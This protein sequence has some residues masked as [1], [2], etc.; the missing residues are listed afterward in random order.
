MKIGIVGLPNV[1]KST[2]FKA[3][4][5]KQVDIQNYPFC[6]ID[7]NIG[8][9]EV[10]DER[11]RKLAIFSQSKKIVPTVIEFV[12][13][14]GLVKGAAE[15]AGLGNKFLSHIREVDAIAQVIRIFENPDIIHVPNKIDPISDIETINLE[16]IFKDLDTVN[17]RLDKTAR[18]AKT[19]D[20][21]T[22][23][24]KI[25]LEIIKTNLE[26]GILAKDI[27]KKLTN[28]QEKDIFQL[29][30][31]ELQLLTS[32]PIFYILNQDVSEI[33]SEKTKN[34]IN[35]I[36]NKFSAPES[37]IIPIDIKLEME[38]AEL[39]EEEQ[40]T[41]LKE[42]GIK[43]RGLGKI[44]KCGY[45]ILNLITYLTTGEDETRA[46]TIK[47]NIKAPQAAAKIHTDFE[48]KFVRAEVIN[49]ETLLDAS[50]FAQARE[51]GFLRTEGK[52]YTV[53]DGDVIEFKI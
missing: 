19:G 18:D 49:W 34:I 45:E 33:E 38:I 50:S 41:Y 47:K 8:I 31:K 7:P 26:N 27:E 16:L 23:A 6:T 20:K 3:L 1:G 39:T 17:K 29:L 13:I 21:D 52:D 9:V 28:K 22:I 24:Q 36:K 4:T 43:E 30:M 12:D 42:L 14:A 46:W 32:K 53:R 51:K 40:K 11:L 5:K 15:G 35:E 10:P 48:K 2:L 44:I 37:Q 25:I